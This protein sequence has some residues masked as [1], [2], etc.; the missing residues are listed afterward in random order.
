MMC[1]ANCFVCWVWNAGSDSVIAEHKQ[2]QQQT[3]YMAWWHDLNKSHYAPKVTIRSCRECENKIV[4][5]SDACFFVVGEEAGVDS[6]S[7]EAEHE[8]KIKTSDSAV[9]GSSLVPSLSRLIS[10]NSWMSVSLWLSNISLCRNCWSHSH[11]KLV[12]DVSQAYIHFSVEALNSDPMHF[13]CTNGWTQVSLLIWTAAKSLEQAK[14]VNLSKNISPAFSLNFSLESF[15][16]L[17]WTLE[18][19]R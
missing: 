19:G 8:R 9:W 18:T 16:R 13:C 3:I 5:E 7:C 11:A 4:C 1:S 17:T 2:Q 6:C 12:T 14:K 10:L 15:R